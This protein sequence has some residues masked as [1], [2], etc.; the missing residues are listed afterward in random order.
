[1]NGVTCAHVAYVVGILALSLMLM[2]QTRLEEAIDGIC[3]TMAAVSLAIPV[4]DTVQTQQM[5]RSWKNWAYG[6]GPRTVNQQLQLNG[7][8]RCEIVA[9][10]PI[11]K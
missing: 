10:S 11:S 4:A 6:Q 5:C 3:R 8:F 9:R 2:F 7:M 1:M